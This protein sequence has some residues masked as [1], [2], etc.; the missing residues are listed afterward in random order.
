M[1]TEPQPVATAPALVQ[2][3]FTQAEEEYVVRSLE[4]RKLLTAPTIHSHSDVLD[5]QITVNRIWS[6]HA[7]LT[8][9]DRLDGYDSLVMRGIDSLKFGLNVWV[10]AMDSDFD[11]ALPE[12]KKNFALAIQY[13]RAADEE[14]DR[15]YSNSKR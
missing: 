10:A 12:A 8:S 2:K 1:V 3:G 4:L 7:D 13:F 6:Q 5:Y 14:L 15:A 11:P 9:S